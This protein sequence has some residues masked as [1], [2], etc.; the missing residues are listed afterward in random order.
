[1]SHSGPINNNGAQLLAR[2]DRLPVMGMHYFWALLLAINL[3]LEYY[4]NAIF[5][6]ASPTIKA[7]TN[8]S[9]EQIGLIGSMFLWV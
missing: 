9:T 8:Y 7:H 2:L 4:D 6:Y 5:A 1:M 3:M